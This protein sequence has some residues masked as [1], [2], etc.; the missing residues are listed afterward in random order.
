[1][2]RIVGIIKI[3]VEVIQ[4]ICTKVGNQEILKSL[5][6]KK[7][8]QIELDNKRKEKNIFREMI[9]KIIREK[10]MDTETMYKL[11]G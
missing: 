5:P 9:N 6:L 7:K 2:I 8:A 11:F 3:T 4:I 10:T 1:M